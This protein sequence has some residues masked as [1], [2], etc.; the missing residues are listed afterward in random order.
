MGRVKKEA[1]E[2]T[3]SVIT[4]EKRNLLKQEAKARFLT[5]GGND[6]KVG[7]TPSGH[8]PANLV[9]GFDQRES[10]G[11]RNLFRQDGRQLVHW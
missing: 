5:F 9:P 10:S 2:R 1:V 6:K 7:H 11:N 4:V 8:E 3:E